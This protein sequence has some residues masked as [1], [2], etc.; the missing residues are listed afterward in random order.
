[1]FVAEET[2]GLVMRKYPP[3]W[4]RKVHVIPPLLDLELG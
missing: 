2:A 3:E 1:M 4:W